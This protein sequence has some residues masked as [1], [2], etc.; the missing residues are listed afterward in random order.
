MAQ[1]SKIQ[2]TDATVNFWT[3]CKKVSAGCKFC[4]MY[5]DKERYGLDPT[6]V[7]RTSDK[8]FYAATKWK[9]PKRIFTCSWSDFFID[10][11]DQWRADAWEVI[12]NTPQHTWMILT[13]RPERILNCLPPD[14]GSTG[15]PNVWL[16]VSV[17]DEDTTW[18]IAY[19]SIIPAVCRFVSFE[20]LLAPVFRYYEPVTKYAPTVELINEMKKNLYWDSDMML[21]TFNPYKSKSIDGRQLVDWVI[22]GGESGNDTGKYRYRP[23][24]IEWFRYLIFHIPASTKIF[25]K[26]LGTHLAKKLN[27]KDRHGGDIDEW[28]DAWLRTRDFPNP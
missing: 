18:R 25:V 9:E 19:F 20:P 16:G 28:E 21:G 5:R 14:W 6:Q 13:K 26:Q 2:W 3:G 22:I 15:Y 8:T 1:E 11:A 24:E 10:E 27:L 4:Y 7:I 12:R 17:E 23:A